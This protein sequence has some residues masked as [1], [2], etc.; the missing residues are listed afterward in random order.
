MFDTSKRA[1]IPEPPVYKCVDPIKWH[2][3]FI[4]MYDRLLRRVYR[5]TGT[6]VDDYMKTYSTLLR[7][8]GTMTK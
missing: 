5:A 6:V 7:Y 4:I 3:H 1:E 8:D 2:P